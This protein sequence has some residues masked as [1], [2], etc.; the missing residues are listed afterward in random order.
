MAASI[1]TVLPP[2]VAAINWLFAWSA[3]VFVMIIIG[4]FWK[5]STNC[6]DCHFLRSVDRKYRLVIH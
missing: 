6:R 5:R 2:I 1:A 4:L 3:P